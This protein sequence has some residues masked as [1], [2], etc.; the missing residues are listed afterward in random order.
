MDIRNLEWPDESFDYVLDK[1]TMD[2]LMCEK[3]DVWQ[4][5]ESIRID[6]ERELEQVMRVLK[7]GGS[8][9][10]V[11]FGQPHFRR[12]VLLSQPWHSFDYQTIGDCFHYYVYHMI[13]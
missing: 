8:F 13:K 3:G 5:P 1:G 4:L 2:A 11:S 12:P 6:C 9:V 7:L 10:Y